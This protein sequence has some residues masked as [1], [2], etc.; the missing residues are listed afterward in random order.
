MLNRYLRHAPKLLVLVVLVAGCSSSSH[1]TKTKSATTSVIPPSASRSAARVAPVL[2]PLTGLGKPSTGPVVAVKIEDTAAGRPQT[3][4]DRADIVFIEQVEGGL[5]RLLAVFDTSL[6]TVEPVRSTRANDPELAMEFGPIAYV[7][8]GGSR[9]ELKPLERSTLRATLNDAGG[10]GFS[11]DNNRSAPNNLRANLRVAGE[12]VKGPAAKSIGLLFSKSLIN[13]SAAGTSLRTTVGGTQVEFR[14]S[15]KTQRYNRYING[16]EQ[17]TTAGTIVS[18]TNVVVQFCRSTVYGADRD[19]LGNPAQYTHTIG[20]GSVV[21]FRGGRRIL[22]TWHR[23][24]V[25]VG[26]HLTDR[27]GARLALA[28]GNTWFVLAATGAALS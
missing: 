4:I 18:T 9:A 14:Y 16:V 2:N 12:R 26:T 19:V 27:T 10:P 5:T 8:S 24:S 22:G 15:P 28:P 17:H 11:R 21:V 6:P 20:S 3:G 13:P 25:T 7:A 23:A 1:S